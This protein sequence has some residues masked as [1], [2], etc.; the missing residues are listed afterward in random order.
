METAMLWAKHRD[1][2]GRQR[3]QRLAEGVLWSLA[4]DSAILAEHA[5]NMGQRDALSRTV[6]LLME[7]GYR[8]NQTTGSAAVRYPCPLTQ[9]D[10]AE[11]LGM[12][13]VHLNR[14]LRYLRDN[15]LLVFNDHEI[16][17][18][19]ASALRRIADFDPAY[20]YGSAAK[21]S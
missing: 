4:R 17:L 13:H 1:P 10:L 5:V 9:K 20:L 3:S 14:I 19:S 15:D 18:L 2:W 7:L 12:T 21:A 6:H 16:T 11:A 8:L